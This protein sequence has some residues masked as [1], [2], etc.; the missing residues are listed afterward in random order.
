M[1]AIASSPRG[2]PEPTAPTPVAP[3]AASPVFDQ[4]LVIGADQAWE[5]PQIEDILEHGSETTADD[6]YDRKRVQI[7]E[8][9]LIDRATRLPKPPRGY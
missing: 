6:D 8:G 9:T 3:L 4:P 2:R 7:I 1:T 5:L